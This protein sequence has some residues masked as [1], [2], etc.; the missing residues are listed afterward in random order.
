MDHALIGA[1][2]KDIEREAS[3][4]MHLPAEAHSM[5]I[6]TAVRRG[7]FVYAIDEKGVVLC[8]IPIGGGTD[9]QLLGYTSQSISVRRGRFTLIYDAKGRQVAATSV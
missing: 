8:V 9:D 5:T 6:S 3:P 7:A 4:K 1:L 2:Y